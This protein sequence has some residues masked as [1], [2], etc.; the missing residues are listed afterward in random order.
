MKKEQILSKRGQF[1]CIGWAR[2]CKTLKSCQA[3]IT[4]E[5]IANNV[6][7]G[8]GY[9]NMKAVQD[10]RASGELPSENQ[11]LKGLEWIEYPYLLVNPKTQKQF[12]RLETAKNTEFKTK[13]YID[14]AETTKREIESYLQASEKKP[15]S[16]M[17]SVM[18]IN[19]E[20]INYPQ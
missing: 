18:N 11:G 5:T 17:P 3:V 1:A 2:P 16:E 13:Y 7:I 15:S 6:R 4:K 8:A 10:A 20:Q 9:D 19:L 12:I 14:G